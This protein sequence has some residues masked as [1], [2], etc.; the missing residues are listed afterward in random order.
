MA[1]NIYENDGSGALKQ[2]EY[3]EIEVNTV[4]KKA[5]EQKPRKKSSSKRGLTAQTK[6]SIVAATVTVFAMA[7]IVLMFKAALNTEYKTLSIQK[8]ELSNLT[9]KVEQL[10]SEIEGGGNVAAVEEKAAELGLHSADKSQVVYIAIDSAD[11]GEILA[12]DNSNRGIH[13]FF[14]KIAAIAEYLY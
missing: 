4:P 12:E 1:S 6:G 7:F 11:G 3:V 9:S 8:T 13:L 5:P 14:N 2:Y 10:S